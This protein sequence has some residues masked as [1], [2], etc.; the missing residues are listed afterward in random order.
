MPTPRHTFS[1]DSE[2]NHPILK[3]ALKAAVPV[4]IP[5]GWG[6][7]QTLQLQQWANGTSVLGLEST[8][9]ARQECPRLAKT[10]AGIAWLLRTA[11]TL[12]ESWSC[13][14]HWCLEPP[15]L[16]SQ[17]AWVLL[18]RYQTTQGLWQGDGLLEGVPS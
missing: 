13:R 4:D 18:Q 2:K 14:A 1:Q 5:F 15:D 8:P 7:S 3:R 16:A 11:G 12:V 17:T 10:S 9:G 6:Q